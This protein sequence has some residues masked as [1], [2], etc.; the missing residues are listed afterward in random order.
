MVS[1]S[2]FLRP[3]CNHLVCLERLLKIGDNVVNVLSADGDT[4]RVLGHTR[5]DAFL[6]RQLL[7]RGRPRV[8]GEGFGVADTG[9]C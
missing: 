4:D 3:I 7:V 8:N 1:H 2:P 9:P 5:V 6:F